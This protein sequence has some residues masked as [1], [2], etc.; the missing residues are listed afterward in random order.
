MTEE[1]SNW[2]AGVDW[3]SEKHQV[4]LLDARGSI[5]GEREF[6]HS[7]RVSPNWRTGSNRSPAQ[8]TRSWLRSK[9]RMVQ[10]STC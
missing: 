3:G 8:R 7:G 1:Q 5:V 10:W 9:F 4:C 2:C 6:A